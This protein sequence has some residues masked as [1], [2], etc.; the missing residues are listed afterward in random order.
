MR[1]C[2]PHFQAA[3]AGGLP[4]AESHLGIATCLGRANDLA[5]AER[6]L[7]EARRLEP[8]NPVVVANVG[9]LQAAGRQPAALQILRAAL[10]A[11]PNLHEARF[12][13]ALVLARPAGGLRR[14]RR[15]ATCSAGSADSAP[16]RRGE[17]GSLE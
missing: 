3:I 5:G 13:L 16:A 8:D 1:A 7:A 14:R 9:I 11:D 17:R 4:G 12:N 2:E 15:L 6:A 10:A